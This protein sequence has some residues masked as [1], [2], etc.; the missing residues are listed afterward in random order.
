MIKS[1][2]KEPLKDAAAMNQ[3][4]KA[5]IERLKDLVPRVLETSAAE[6]KYNRG[7]FGVPKFHAGDAACAGPMSGLTGWETRILAITCV[8]RGKR[9][10]EQMDAHGF[11]RAPRAIMPKHKRI[12]GFATGDMVEGTVTRGANKGVHLGRVTVQSTGQFYIKKGGKK[13][14][15]SHRNTKLVQRGDGYAY[16]L[17]DSPSPPLNTG[18]AG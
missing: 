2:L 15:F 6:T 5:T 11:P 12:H 7:R 13:I 3:T 18:S 8:G 4:R 1:R 10:R 16:S 17:E 9:Q 14:C